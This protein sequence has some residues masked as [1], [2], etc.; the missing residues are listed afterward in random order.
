M[1]P[2]LPRPLARRRNLVGAVI[3]IVSLILVG[4]VALGSDAG[5]S[6]TVTIAA[7]SVAYVSQASPDRNLC[8][9]R[10]ALVNGSTTAAKTM[11]IQFPTSS[12]PAGATISTAT[13]TLYSRTA[14]ANAVV[15]AFDRDVAVDDGCQ[16]TWATMGSYGSRLGAASGPKLSAY[17]AIPLSEN[18]AQIATGGRTGF[19]VTTDQP[20]DLK[21]QTDAGSRPPRLIV[22]YST[23]PA[24][25]SPS[26]PASTA[27]PATMTTS[28]PTST[29]TGLLP[30][31]TTGLLST[32]TTGAPKNT[33]TSSTT[34]TSRPAT[35]TTTFGPIATT[36]TTTTAPCGGPLTITSGG[37]YGGCHE[38]ATNTPAVTIATSAPVT[39]S[40]MTIRHKG[41]GVFAQS[42]RANLTLID[43]VITALAPESPTEQLSLY[44]YR[45]AALVIEYNQITDGHGITINGDGLTTSPFRISHNN[46]TDIGRY[47]AASC[48]IGPVHTDKVLAPGGKIQWNRST[49]TYGR[50]L[51]EDAF[52]IYQTNGGT[53]NPI[54]IGHNLVNGAYP[55][56]GNGSGFTGGAFDFGDSGGSWLF[57]HDNTAVNYTNNGFMIPSGDHIT[58]KDSVA[59]FD[60]RAGFS[61][62]G[63][64]V[65]STF[66]N[67]ITTWHNPS[68]GPTT[69]ATVTGMS[70]GHL[71]WN[72]GR[73]ER[74]DYNLP[75]CTGCAYSGNT[76]R[77]P[78]N[79]AAEQAAV[80]AFEAS[81]VAAG[82]TIG[83]RP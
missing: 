50:S 82:V 74:A 73:W 53:N 49:A 19:V 28:A 34:T 27:A 4:S 44:A 26:T 24:A 20:D 46:F 29:T 66:G 52:G 68:Y 17:F 57:G 32:A 76:S 12:V 65:S 2:D 81:V 31:V 25:T 18:L 42:A 38:S 45:P 77:D 79:G 8:G 11:L 83:P 3:T 63:P 60:G 6:T 69:N 48:C 80:D 14:N 58:H 23:K 9:G 21:F 10:Y 41:N 51:I 62:S 7:D 30:T 35:T 13:L 72:N 64:I 1:S 47:N 40:R 55:F 75:S 56:S 71:R 39:I 78:V 16:V 5:G 22:T 37:T 67:G 43:S 54:D 70:I 33:T 15:S 59:V 61:D 36:T